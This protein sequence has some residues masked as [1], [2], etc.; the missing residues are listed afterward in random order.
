[1]IASTQPATRVRW[2]PAWS[3]RYSAATIS[4]DTS[5]LALRG[6][7][8]IALARAQGAAEGRTHALAQPTG[9]ARR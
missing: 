4:L 1:V 7:N 6:R 5:D 8:L 2:P 3:S 9:R